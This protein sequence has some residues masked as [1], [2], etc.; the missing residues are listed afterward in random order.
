MP[1]N[2]DA[3]SKK[4]FGRLRRELRNNWRSFRL[5]L[6]TSTAFTLSSRGDDEAA[7]E[8]LKATE[9]SLG[10]FLHHTFGIEP[11]LLQVFTKGNISGLTANDYDWLALRD[12]ILSAPEYNSAEKL[13]L[14]AYLE[15]LATTAGVLLPLPALPELSRP[16]ERVRRGLR[17]RFPKLS[18]GS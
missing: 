14:L 17:A 18:M 16:S 15:E 1:H 7:H 8:H 11:A 9:R 10:P 2:H 12:H 6:R 4:R 3:A 13:H 5:L